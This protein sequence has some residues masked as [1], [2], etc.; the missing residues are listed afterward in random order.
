MLF[1]SIESA[2]RSGPDRRLQRLPLHIN[3]PAFAEALIGAW[4]DVSR[5]A[6]GT[7]RA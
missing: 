7:R 1:S 4:H 6:A 2:F 3:D 5:P